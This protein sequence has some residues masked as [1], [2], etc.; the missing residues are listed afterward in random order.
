MLTL[1]QLKAM[2]PHTMFATGVA[3]NEPKGLF[4]TRERQGDTIR[5]VAKRGEIHDWTIYCHWSCQNEQWIL[6]Q[7]DKVIDKTHIQRLVPCNDE[8]FAMYRL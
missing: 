4:M 5:W 1:E 8:A 3:V 6:R 7:G 2:P